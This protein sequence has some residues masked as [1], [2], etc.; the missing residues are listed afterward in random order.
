MLDEQRQVAL[1]HPLARLLE[2]E[3]RSMNT[4]VI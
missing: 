4:A 3:V 1:P 2:L